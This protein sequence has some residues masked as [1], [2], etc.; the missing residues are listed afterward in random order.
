[1][2]HNTVVASANSGNNIVA[3]DANS[4]VQTGN[5]GS[6]VGITNLIN[7]LFYQSNVYFV[8]INIFGTLNGDIGDASKFPSPTPLLPQEGVVSDGI[9]H[10]EDGGKLLLAVTNNVGAFVYPGDTVTITAKVKN[11]GS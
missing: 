8:F 9:T 11:T 10:K 5:A 2:V 6:F 1:I 3:G 4:T 7:S